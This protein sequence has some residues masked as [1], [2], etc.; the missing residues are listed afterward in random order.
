ML[1]FDIP[2]A[3][4]SRPERVLRDS[5][6]ASGLYNLSLELGYQTP[7]DSSGLGRWELYDLARDRTELH[8]LAAT[9]PDDLERLV[10]QWSTWADRV[11]VYPDPGFDINGGPG[12][13]TKKKA[14]PSTAPIATVPPAVPAQPA[15]IA[16]ADLRIRDPFV[17]ADSTNHTYNLYRQM[18][19]GQGDSLKRAR[20]VEVFQS[21]DLKT[22]SGPTTTFSAPEDFW[23]N[24]E[25][26]APEMHAYK[27]K[28]YLFVTFTASKSLS[29]SQPGA[30]KENPRRGTQILVGE[31]PAGP[32]RPFANHAHTPADWMS[33]DGTFWVEDGVPWM[34]FCHEWLQVTDGTME[35][36]Q[37]APDLSG[38]VGSAQR[39]FHASD[40]PWVKNLREHGF[41]RDGYV[42]DGPFLFRTKTDK[43]LMIWSS[44]GAERYA[45][46][47]AESTSGKIAGP[48]IQQPERLIKADGGHGM[49]FRTFE[50]QLMMSIHQPNQSP[51]ERMH[52][53]PLEDTGDSL[54]VASPVP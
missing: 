36:L 2:A 42:T 9:R 25:V 39:L 38:P 30:D 8:D 16:T 13:A 21:K 31:T 44:F 37:L 45:V 17:F 40:A 52:L 48:W 12:T 20:G 4:K 10:A 3:S 11:Q 28:F 51:L 47:I 19:N 22:W 23:S 43:L 5:R 49:I 32:F 7:L 14:A 27:G 15:G 26:W 29:R 54:R 35:L 53:I 1:I 41:K 50:G 24:A 46:G 18:A 6:P 33:L 34:V